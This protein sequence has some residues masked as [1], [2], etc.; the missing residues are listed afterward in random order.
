M[1]LWYAHMASKRKND[2]AAEIR[3]RQEAF[4]QFA[5]I[6]RFEWLT[7][8]PYVQKAEEEILRDT[9]ASCN[10][11]PILEVGCGE[12]AA[13][14]TLRRLR[15]CGSYIGFDCFPE[16]IRFCTARHKDATFLVSDARRGLPFRSEVFECILVRDVLHHLAEGEREKLLKESMR[17]LRPRGALCI[18]EGNANNPIAFIFALLFKHERCMLETRSHLLRR[19]VERAVEPIEVKLRMEEPSTLFRLLFH[20]RLGFPRMG[21]W[22]GVVWML[23]TWGALMRR[24]LPQK[25]WAYSIVM[26]SKNS[27]PKYGGI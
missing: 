19:F 24:V 2:S 23:E 12:G 10:T 8:H 25:F 5:E 18:I 7:Q 26:V 27:A 4:Y 22:K 17:V 20:F 16:K 14:P 11:G 3:I 15:A 1:P 13:L 21:K 6:A 9:A